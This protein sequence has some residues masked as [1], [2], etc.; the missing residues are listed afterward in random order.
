M[1]LNTPLKVHLWPTVNEYQQHCLQYLVK[2]VTQKR[3]ADEQQKVVAARSVKINEEEITCKKLAEVVE[4]DLK[5]AMPA[6]E[7]AMKVVNGPMFILPGVE[8]CVEILR[9]CFVTR[10]FVLI[11]LWLCQYVV[12][13]SHITCS[14]KLFFHAVSGIFTAL[15]ST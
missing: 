15:K 13:G 11:Y 9:Q 8:K 10:F 3:E 2:T 7:A 4:A 5:E 12:R 1:Q 6:L 14:Q